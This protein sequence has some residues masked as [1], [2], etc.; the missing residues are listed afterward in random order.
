MDALLAS[1]WIRVPAYSVVLL[2]FQGCPGILPGAGA[3]RAQ[4]AGLGRG[5]ECFPS[6][7]HLAVPR[8]RSD[9]VR[10]FGAKR[11]SWAGTFLF[12]S[13]SGSVLAQT[14][15]FSSRGGDKQKGA[16]KS[17]WLTRGSARTRVLFAKLDCHR[18]LLR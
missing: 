6:R 4:S 13:L 3:D 18:R 2:T 9:K 1:K 17:G 8:A 12:V 5:G 15:L 14:I 10:V 11:A 7:A 16:L